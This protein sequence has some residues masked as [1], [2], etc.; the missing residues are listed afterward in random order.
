[1]LFQLIA[2]VPAFTVH[3]WAHAFVAHRLGDPT[4]RWQGRLTLNPLRHIDWIGLIL[5]FAFGFGWA[6]PVPVNP[7]YFSNP[8]RGLLFVAVAGPLSNILMAYVAIAAGM[9]TGVLGRPELDGPIQEFLGIFVFLNVGL[10]VFNLIP[11]PPLDGSKILA[12]LLPERQAWAM[13]R[14]EPYGWLLLMLLLSTDILRTPMLLARLWLVRAL[15][16]TAAWTTQL[17]SVFGG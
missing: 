14:L 3:E 17:S 4:P 2:L 8:R 7:G 11:V 5:L 6:R 12:G 10:A 1:M 9:S 16:A 13:Q 15:M